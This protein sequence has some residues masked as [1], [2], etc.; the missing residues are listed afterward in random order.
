VQL[1]PDD[2]GAAPAG[3]GIFSLV[4]NGTTTTE[5]GVPAA[6][7]TTSARIYIDRSAGHDTGLAVVNTGSSQVT[8]RAEA[9]GA[10][11]ATVGTGTLTLNANG[12]AAK[13]AGSIVGGLAEG[14]TGVFE[15]SA[16][17]PF[18]AVTLRSLTNER[19]D[20]LITTFPVADMTR[21]SPSPMVFPQVVAGGGYGT[22]FVLLN[23]GATEKQVVLRFFDA[24]GKPAAVS[25]LVVGTGS[26]AP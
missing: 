22:E 23:A 17:T 5:S 19:G 1:V 6:L 25:T 26:A 21:A 13:F 11:A 2:G 24:T 18:A 4:Q 14:F 16:P 15:I 9:F 10:A 7:A 3:A 12:H 20:F 8:I